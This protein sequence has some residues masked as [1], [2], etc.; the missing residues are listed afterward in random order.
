MSLNIIPT[1]SI[2][3]ANGSAKNEKIAFVLACLPD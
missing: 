1:E 3:E 2:K